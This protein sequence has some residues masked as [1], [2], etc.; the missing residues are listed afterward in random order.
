[1]SPASSQRKWEEH[2]HVPSNYETLGFDV[3]VV[4]LITIIREWFEV[5]NVR[6]V[7]DSNNGVIVAMT[8]HDAK[9]SGLPLTLHGQ[10]MKQPTPWQPASLMLT[11]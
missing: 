4:S 3:T 8:I 6:V 2:H 7:L 10:H 5:G 11:R 9:C 1:M